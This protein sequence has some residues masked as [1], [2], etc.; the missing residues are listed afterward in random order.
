MT[1]RCGL[2]IGIVILVIQAG[3][4]RDAL[5]D[6]QWPEF[7]VAVCSDGSVHVT[8]LPG[9][10]LPADGMGEWQVEPYNGT[11]LL[12]L[13]SDGYL[14]G[15]FARNPIHRKLDC[16]GRDI[17]QAQTKLLQGNEVIIDGNGQYMFFDRNGTVDSGNNLHLFNDHIEGL[18][19]T[20][21]PSDGATPGNITIL[22]GRLYAPWTDIDKQDGIHIVGMTNASHLAYLKINANGTVLIGPSNL[23]G[24][25]GSND[26]SGWDIRID[27]Q[28]NVHVVYSWWVTDFAQLRYTKLDGD[29]HVIVGE[30]ALIPN[31]GRLDDIFALYPNI[32]IDSG[33]NI[34]I[35]WSGVTREDYNNPQWDV[36]YMELDSMGNILSRPINLTGSESPPDLTIPT[37]ILVIAVTAMIILFVLWRK[38]KTRSIARSDTIAEGS[39]AEDR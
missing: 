3:I 21:I 19:H 7:G 2:A 24:S 22:T 27:H 37:L 5:A 12:Q 6:Q 13:G 28:G 32:A 9:H 36:Y 20:R 25:P 23:T 14:Y 8:G 16:A 29:G 26:Y 34:H 31:N 1:T 30:T 11:A 39:V 17:G 18:A 4:T 35:A 38:R 33:N 10:F 15:E